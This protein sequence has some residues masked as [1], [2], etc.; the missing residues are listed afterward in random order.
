MEDVVVEKP[1]KF[2]KACV[3]GVCLAYFHMYMEVATGENMLILVSGIKSIKEASFA[4]AH[5]G[6][7]CYLLLLFMIYYRMLQLW[8]GG[9]FS[10]DIEHCH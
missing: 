3:N 8:N 9:D 5:N 4:T 2:A 6:V 10:Y 1:I 7:C